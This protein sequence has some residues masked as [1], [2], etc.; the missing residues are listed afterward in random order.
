MKAFLPTPVVIVNYLCNVWEI[1]SSTKQKMASQ[2][3]YKKHG[4][5]V[6]PPGQ[7]DVAY[8]YILPQYKN[9]NVNELVDG[10]YYFSSLTT[11]RKAIPNPE[12]VARYKG[13]YS[14]QNNTVESRRK[15]KIS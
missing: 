11:L 4:V 12:D 14:E 10:V 15:R 9:V 6:K 2:S 5:I 1:F 13:A 3:E 7:L 8:R